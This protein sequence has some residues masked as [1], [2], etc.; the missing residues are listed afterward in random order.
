MHHKITALSSIIDA[1]QGSEFASNDD[2]VTFSNQISPKNLFFSR[3]IKKKKML[4]MSY[5][6]TQLV[7]LTKIYIYTNIQFG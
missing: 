5:K 7:S 2:T 3:I 4:F 1:W 6:F